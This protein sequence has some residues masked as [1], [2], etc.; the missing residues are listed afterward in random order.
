M[1]LIVIL[2]V[3]T[4]GT[5]LV[6][7]IG[8]SIMSWLDRI[9]EGR[10]NLKW[11]MRSACGAF[12]IIGAVFTVGW[13]LE[14]PYQADKRSID[15]VYINFRSALE[16]RNF[17]SAYEHM[18]PDYREANP[19][20]E[21]KAQFRSLGTTPEPLEPGR[22]LDVS[23]R[24][25]SLFPGSDHWPMSGLVYKFIKIGSHWYFTGETDRFLD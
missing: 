3:V 2:S 20:S 19:I 1:N 22:W 15:R 5:A 21:F 8:A 12:A 13:L 7:C 24:R 6:L 17:G 25:A 11:L 14:W 18:S 16:K 4:G 9:P 10:R 23:G